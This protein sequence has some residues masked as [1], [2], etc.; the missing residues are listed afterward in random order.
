MVNQSAITPDGRISRSF[1]LPADIC[2]MPIIPHSGEDVSLGPGIR[3]PRGAR[4]QTSGQGF[5]PSTV[6][7]TF[8]GQSYY[9]FARDLEIT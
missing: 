7:I 9:V 2:A 1:V 8:G 4:V 5:N 6:R 3:L